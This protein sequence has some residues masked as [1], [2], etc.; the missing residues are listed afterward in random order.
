M[1]PRSGHLRSRSIFATAGIIGAIKFHSPSVRSVSWRRCSGQ[2]CR[3][4]AGVY[5]RLLQNGFDIQFGIT[6]APATQ[7]FR[8][9]S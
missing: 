7:P 5:I 8:D 3:R 6:K 4:V 1:I 2:C 9:G